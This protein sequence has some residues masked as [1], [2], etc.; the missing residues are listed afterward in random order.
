MSSTVTSITAQSNTLFTGLSDTLQIDTTVPD[1]GNVDLNFDIP[2]LPTDSFTAH[3]I[4]AALSVDDLTSGVVGGTGIF[5]KLMSAVNAHIKEQADKGRLTTSEFGAVYLGGLQATLDSSVQFL[6]GR[7]RATWEAIGL[8]ANALTAAVG[9][10]RAKA[11]VVT[12]KYAAVNQKMVAGRVAIEAHT[13]RA[14]YAGSKLNLS[15]TFQQ[16]LHSEAETGLVEEQYDSA[17]ADTKDTLRDGITPIGGIRHVQK[18]TA[19]AQRELTHSQA[20]LTNEQYETARAQTKNTLSDGTAIGGLVGVEKQTAEANRQLVMEQVDTA[21][22]QTKNTTQQGTPIVGLVGA[23][24]KLADWQGKLAEEQCDTARAQTKETLS[25]GQPVSG[26]ASVEK[27]LKQAQVKLVSEQYE[28][29][30]GQTR[31]TLSTGETVAGVMGAQKALYEQQT[32][33]YRHDS[34]HKGVK[35]MLDTWTTRKSLDDGVAVPLTVEVTAINT[36]MTA[37]QEAIGIK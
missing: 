35:A 29:Q 30:R 15:A 9:L 28:S 16:V 19:E 27:A 23:Q 4:P 14:S 25:T 24:I 17:R 7:D 33:S 36:A 6:L 1:V 22:G 8:R 11:E 3:K 12:A 20:Q 34:M 2:D 32:I 26:I 18:L 37:Y 21:R 13:A 10:V 5:D 31:G